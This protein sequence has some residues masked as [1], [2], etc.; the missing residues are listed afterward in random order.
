MREEGERKEKGTEN[1]LP[2]FLPSFLSS[3]SGQSS[4]GVV[5][6][7]CQYLRLLARSN[8]YGVSVVH[9][10]APSL[11]VVNQT[12]E[13]T[14]DSEAKVFHVSLSNTPASSTTAATRC[15][16]LSVPFNYIPG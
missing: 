1:F 5:L 7:E 10:D 12:S 6:E 9:G 14:N 4:A 11:L 8:V 3:M 16:S 15:N 13:D 2:S